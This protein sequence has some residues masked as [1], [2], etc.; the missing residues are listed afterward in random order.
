[1]RR[2]AAMV[3]LCVQNC[4]RATLGVWLVFLWL[5]S[6]L[7]SPAATNPDATR[8]LLGSP[9]LAGVSRRVGRTEKQKRQRTVLPAMQRSDAGCRDD[10][11]AWE[12]TGPDS[13]RVH[14]VPPSNERDRAGDRLLARSAPDHE[15]PRGEGGRASAHPDHGLCHISMRFCI[16]RCPLSLAS[17]PV[18]NE[19]AD[20]SS[21]PLLSRISQRNRP[22]S[23]LP[24]VIFK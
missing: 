9:I 10:R 2:A 4:N 5:L 20:V 21:T 11:A 13:V 1:M 19:S 16:S 17:R 18:A 14:G 8:Y 23:S 22:A 3:L 7:F 12:R 15:A 24:A 6:K